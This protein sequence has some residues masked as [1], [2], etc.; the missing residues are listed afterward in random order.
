MTDNKFVLRM[1]SAV[2]MVGM[3]L[4][5]LYAFEPA[6]A[7]S[8]SSA[9]EEPLSAA[10]DISMN[11]TGPGCTPD[12]TNA[13]AYWDLDETSGT[14]F[15][16]SLG[17][18]HGN[19]VGD[20][21]P[22]SVAGTT[23]GG[24][25][26]IDSDKDLISIPSSTDFEFTASSSFSV[27]AWVKTT[28]DCSGRK[29][30]IGRYHPTN[31]AGWIGCEPEPGDTGVGFAAFHMRDSTGFSDTA[32]GNS[33]IN[34]G[35]WHYVV[36]VRNGTTNENHIY[37]DGF[38]EDNVTG[39]SGDFILGTEVTIGAY[40]GS[41]NYFNGVIDEVAIFD[42][43][44]A[45][46]NMATCTFDPDVGDVTFETDQDTA[47]EIT[48]AGLLSNSNP[49]GDNLSIESVAL[50]SAKGGTITGSGPYQYSPPV[51]Y[52][53]IDFFSFIVND[54]T[55]TAQGLAIITINMGNVP[56]V[57]ENPGSQKNIEDDVVALQI[58]ATDANQDVLTYGQ[59]G[60]PPG[61]KIDTSTGLINGT[62]AAGASDLSPFNVKVSVNDGEAAPVEVS[63]DW[64]VV[65]DNSPPDVTNPGD[66]TNTEGDDVNLQIV[67]TDS[68]GDILTYSATDLPPGLS[69]NSS[70]GLISGA[71]DTGASAFDPYN[72]TVAVDD[73]FSVPVEVT[74]NW[75]VLGE[76]KIYLPIITK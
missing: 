39:F 2:L 47:L 32:V 49:N 1:I 74:F 27:G 7:N 11:A 64:T 15:D 44:L 23:N 70:T 62:I 31:G 36:G 53:G 29:V 68:D 50:S 63:F 28:Q 54:G 30:F 37:V 40:T 67:A 60:L 51:S 24:Q 16:D 65:R 58:I 59:S 46:T 19:C 33:R 52:F 8:P 26:F 66:Q 72:V 14:I 5:F 12:M 17:T 43:A 9:S 69:I 21:C 20:N 42:T 76:S 61:L 4:G 34:D 73:G 48:E 41:D 45:G 35:R 3:L 75:T 57:V 6:Q 71:I 10:V 56:P 38:S 18:N 13:I 22:T 25:F 55:N